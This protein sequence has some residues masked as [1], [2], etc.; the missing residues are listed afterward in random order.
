MQMSEKKKI[1]L[2]TIL[3]FL[4]AVTILLLVNQKEVE[5]GSEDIVDIE[6]DVANNEEDVSLESL[7]SVIELIE[8]NSDSDTKEIGDSYAEVLDEI[9]SPIKL[10]ALLNQYFT[11]N[12]NSQELYAKSP[13]EFLNDKGGSTY[14]YAH[15]SARVLDNLGLV[16][17]VLRYDFVEDQEDKTQV[18]V[19]F[20]QGD[21][22][23]YISFSE[24]EVLLFNYYGSS[25]RDLLR[26][27][28]IRLGMEVNRYAYFP[29]NVTDFSKPVTPFEWIDF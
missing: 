29:S 13:E 15:F 27:E 23:A 7:S 18:L 17:G 11:F 22:P 4:V 19:T 12:S 9:N 1:I 25:F 20:R 14:D 2:L 26:A 8:A 16:V 10:V 6:R 21:Q 28:E 24:S 3:I 5:E